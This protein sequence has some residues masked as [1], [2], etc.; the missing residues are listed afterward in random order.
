LALL[1]AVADIDVDLFHKPGDLRHHVDFLERLE[2]GG[3]H[4]AVRQILRGY[5]GD[6][7]GG[8]VGRPGIAGVHGR[9]FRTG[10]GKIRRSHDE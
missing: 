2:F 1:H 8:D 3:Q 10:C 6:C 7:H 9:L 4:E 5:L